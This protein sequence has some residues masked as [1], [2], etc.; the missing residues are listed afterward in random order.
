MC[1]EEQRVSQHLSMSEELCCTSE[2]VL[3][4]G[5]ASATVCVGSNAIR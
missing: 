2:S 1:R 5:A 3:L 4:L